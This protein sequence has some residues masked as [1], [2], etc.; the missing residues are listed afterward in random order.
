MV[1]SAIVVLDGLP[2]TANGKVDRRALP[3]PEGRPEVGAYVAPRNA[4]EEAL[5]AIWC[6]VL[7]LDRVGVHDNFFELG[8]HSLVATRV[9]MRIQRQFG[10]AMPLRQI[11]ETPTIM[12][13]ADRID[14]FRWIAG[15][16]GS[17]S[18]QSEFEH[19]EG[20]L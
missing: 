11:F 4:T 15:D 2:L 8:G 7:R 3:A 13:L 10:I 5:A 12:A 20:I 1:P 16:V 17:M 9:V 18:P 14:T 6:E 19:E